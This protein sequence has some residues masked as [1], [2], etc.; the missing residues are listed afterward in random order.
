MSSDL[1]VQFVSHGAFK[2][3][4][5]KKISVFI[6]IIIVIISKKLRKLMFMILF[7]FWIHN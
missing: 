3:T 7:G 5:C 4:I 2:L 6:I 1:F